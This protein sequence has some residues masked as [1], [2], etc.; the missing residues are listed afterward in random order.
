MTKKGSITTTQ[1]S[2][3]ARSNPASRLSTIA[4][5]IASAG[6]AAGLSMSVLAELGISSRTQMRTGNR[7]V[8]FTARLKI[9]SASQSRSPL[10]QMA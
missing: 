4:A 3:R 1:Q 8:H 2:T 6:S 5:S 9:I 10:R 7:A